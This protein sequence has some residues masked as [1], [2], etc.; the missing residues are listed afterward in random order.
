M[1]TPR[2]D[3]STGSAGPSQDSARYDTLLARARQLP[4]EARHAWLLNACGDDD[5]L[6]AALSEALGFD[7][8]TVDYL[9]AAA[10][11]DV[12]ASAR[13]AARIAESNDGDA[14]L[15]AR[16][17]AYRVMERLG[18]GGMGVVYLA[19][20]TRTDAPRRVAIKFLTDD[21]AIVNAKRLADE[22]AALIALD[23]PNI[24]QV[25]DGGE[26]ASG[27][28]YQVMAYVDGLPIDR[29]CDAHQLDARATVMLVQS[30]CDAVAR[31]H[32]QRIV[33]RD[34]KPENVLVTE[35]G[36]PKL[37]DFGIARALAAPTGGRP[38]TM[39]LEPAR[40]FTPRYASPEQVQ[41][42]PESVATDIYALGVLLFELLT[43][44]SPY[45][46]IAVTPAASAATI[47]HAVLNDEFRR[48]SQVA[49]VGKFRTAGEIDRALD[50]IIQRASAKASAERFTSAEGFSEALLA[51]LAAPAPPRPL[52]TRLAQRLTG[53]FQR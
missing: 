13:A 3:L 8:H 37:L 16:V 42:L 19:E 20:S 52:L 44:Q 35:R 22:R 17:G 28:P 11:P 53:I 49:K 32:Q 30:L 6:L 29:Y 9:S 21:T 27:V 43:G 5:A 45:Q 31:A 41:G 14:Y 39:S 40:H 46:R 15:G 33:H 36:V 7:D 47:M 26:T 51:W 48:A 24:A 38:T 4:Q 10:H 23:H 2:P 50:A 12:F 18:A 25:L 34:I 1:T